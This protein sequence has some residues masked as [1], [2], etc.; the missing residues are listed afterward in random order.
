MEATHHASVRRTPDPAEMYQRI[1]ELTRKLHDAMQQL[2]YDKKIEASLGAVPDARSRLSFIAKVTGEAAEKVLNMVDASQAHQA[3]LLAD[4]DRMEALLKSDPV[5]AVA[6]GEVLHFIGHVRENSQRTNSQLTEIMM[7]QDFHDLTGQT[8][9]KVI[10]V[11]A[12]LEHSLVMLLVEGQGGTIPAP[13]PAHVEVPLGFLN[14]P[15]PDAQGR[16][17]IVSD[18]AGVDSLLESLGF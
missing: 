18:Q 1:G 2:G 7:A 16:T 14:G 12:N 13:G 17:D 6:R 11:A 9:R 4:A 10:D 8:V 3:T 5:G 15:V